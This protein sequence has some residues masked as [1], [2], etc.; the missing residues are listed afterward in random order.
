MSAE[1]AY[2][3]LFAMFPLALLSVAVLGLVGDVLGREDLVRAV[4]SQV[5]PLLPPV[6]AT[7]TDAL[8][9][10]L[11]ARAKTFAIV[12]LVAA[13][14]GAASGVG[15]LIKG[16]DRA[17]GIDRPRPTWLRIAVGIVAALLAPPAGLVLLVASVAA[18][19]ITT[20]LGASLGITAPVAILIT[21]AQMIVTGVVFFIG[22]VIVYGALPTIRQRL[23]EVVPGAIVAT[24]GWLALTQTFGIVVANLGGERATYGAFAAAISFLLWLYLVSIVILLGAEVNALLFSGR[25]SWANDIDHG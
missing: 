24:A 4:V 16:I 14:W 20:W 9:A 18:H 15:A 21:A 13:L 7:S 19:G 8:V 25:Q 11:I 6:I 1:M 10:D 5:T 2:R 3:F 12:A 22:I 23:R 17:Y